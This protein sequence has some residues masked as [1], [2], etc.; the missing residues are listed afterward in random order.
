MICSSHPL[1]GEMIKSTKTYIVNICTIFFVFALFLSTFNIKV[2]AASER[3]ND[4]LMDRV[5]KDFTKKFCNGIGFGLSKESAMNFASKE[6][7][8][9]FQKKKGIN[10]LDK[11]LVANKIAISVAD[12]C[13]Y[14]INI[15]N[16]KDIEEFENI[17]ISINNSPIIEN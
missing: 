3:T 8:L 9:T 17:Y 16:E 1:L 11:E 2:L 5:S 6:N 14:A 7:N 4:K 10:S 15:T 13:G 12:S